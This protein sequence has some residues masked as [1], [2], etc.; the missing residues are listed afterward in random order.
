MEERWDRSIAG[1]IRRDRNH[2]SIVMWGMLNEVVDGRLFRHA[3]QALQLVRDIDET[4]VVMLNSGRFDR[5][6]RVGSFSNPGSREWGGVLRD[7]HTYPAFPHTAAITQAMREPDLTKLLGAA[8]GEGPVLLSEFG[9]CG[10]QDYPGFMRHAESL[11]M[12][13]APDVKLFQEKLERFLEDWPKWRLEDCWAR[14]EDYFRESQKNQA[15]LA[16]GDFNTWLSNPALIGDFTSTQVPDAWFHGCGIVD[17][18]RELKPGMADAFNDMGAKARWSLFVEPVNLYCG[19]T[20][21]LEA[22]LVNR[23]AGL[24]PGKFPVRLQVVGPKAIPVFDKTVEVQIPG[25][26]GGVEPPFVFPVFAE[27]VTIN[28]PTGKY[29]FLAT[30]QKGV[31]AA[32]GDVEFYATSK[33]DMPSVPHEIVL[34]GQDEGLRNWLSKEGFRVRAFDATNTGGRE[35][36][37]ASGQP[38][39]PG[40]AQVFAELADRI[41]RGSSVVFLTYSTMAESASLGGK[42]I[43]LR[44]APFPSAIKPSIVPIANWY[45]RADHWAKD[46][47]IFDGLPCGGIMNYRFY[48]EIL[49]DRVFAGLHPPL[50]AVGGALDTSQAY[51]SDLLISVHTLGQGRVVLNSLKIRENLGPQPAAERLLRNLLNYSGGD[52]AKPLANPPSNFSEQLKSMGYV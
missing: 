49:S 21:H 14:P 29:R 50:E 8:Q 47:P 10:A 40:G 31:A 17:S 13:S 45:F 7:V 9:V 23:D 42:T 28:G 48:R 35:V 4:R 22:V 34:W 41:V 51:Q 5:D 44:W 46:H 19:S 16:C 52:A 12:S 6:Y 36:I 18:F 15:T 25:E 39:A 24:T 32:G 27:D 2:P 38:P 20:V 37:L 33:G 11:G 3:V 43:P 1:V 26:S 30:F